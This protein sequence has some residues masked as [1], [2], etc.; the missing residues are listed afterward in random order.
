MNKT[1]LLAHLESRL[2]SR[3]A[4]VAALDAVLAEIQDAVAAGDRV[5]LTGFGTFEP[6][7]RAAR[8]GRDPR[9]GAALAIA[10]S[11]TPRFRAG[12]GL[13]AAVAGGGTTDRIAPPKTPVEPAEAGVAAK[14]AKP[15]TPAK[16]AKPAASAKPAKSAKP[17]ASAKPA[18]AAKSAKSAKSAK[19]AKPA[20]SAKA[21]KGNGSSAKA[22][23]KAT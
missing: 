9:T 23:K 18:K 22:K 10:A 20:K 7:A 1:E 21:G 11:T 15:A 5:V 16:S 19:A 2:G 4:A 12:A 3:G 17:A 8:T 6:V 13:R 14:P